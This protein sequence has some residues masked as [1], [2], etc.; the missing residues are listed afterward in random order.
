M[1]EAEELIICGYSLSQADNLATSLFSNFE[2]KRIGTIKVIDPNP[3]V[4]IKWKTLL[5]RKNIKKTKWEYYMDFEE[6]FP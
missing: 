3:E 6:Y 2:N 5:T 4:L 1:H